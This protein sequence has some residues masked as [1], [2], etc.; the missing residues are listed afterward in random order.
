[1]DPL[2]PQAAAALWQA[3][4]HRVPGQAGAPRAFGVPELR[5]TLSFTISLISIKHMSIES[6]RPSNHL[7]LCHPL[8]LMLSIFPS[9]RVFS[10]ESALWPKYWNFSISPSNEYS[11]LISLGL[12]GLISLLSKELSG[13]FSST[14]V[15]KHQFF[16]T[17]PSSWFKSHI[18]T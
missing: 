14:T 17:Q 6:V 8:F 16:F 2:T 15:R 4:W 3:A 5:L 1:M 18:H 13:V 7:I 11:G 10:K 12:T 9:I